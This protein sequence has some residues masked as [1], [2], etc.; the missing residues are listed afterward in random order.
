MGGI[1]ETFDEFLGKYQDIVESDE[2]EIKKFIIQN[3]DELYED[4]MLTPWWDELVEKKAREE[5]EKGGRY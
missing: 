5:Y 2:G 4:I 1:G 3:L